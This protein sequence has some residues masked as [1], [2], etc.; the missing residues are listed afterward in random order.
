MDRDF[1]RF[2]QF[3]GS[4]IGCW[5]TL[6]L[7]CWALGAI[8]L[9]WLVNSFFIIFGLLLISP[10]IAWFI[11]RWW[12]QRNLI[13]DECPVCNFQFSGFNGVDCRCPSCGEPLKVEGGHFKRLTPPGTIDVE[14][15]EV[16]A[17]SLE[18]S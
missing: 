1:R 6:L 5:L 8:G 10:V 2:S 4:G 12:V 11:F 17:Q 14:A 16:S 9:G 3:N 13:E 15:I 7:V 18:D